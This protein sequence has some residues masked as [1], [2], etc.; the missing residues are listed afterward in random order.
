M[1]LS[2]VLLCSRFTLMSGGSTFESS[3][4]LRTPFTHLRARQ[5]QRFVEKRSLSFGLACKVSCSPQ[6]LRLD[7]CASYSS[8]DTCI[9]KARG[10]NRRQAAARACSTERGMNNKP[11]MKYVVVTGGTSSFRLLR[12]AC[13][14][15]VIRAS[16][17]C[18]L[19]KSST[20]PQI[21]PSDPVTSLSFLP[22]CRRR[23]RSWEGRDC[24]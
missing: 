3:T 22:R 16:L 17:S 24:Q 2:E 5:G 4:S 13:S 11:P 20:T 21:A 23:Q 10:K 8:A 9:E 18:R 15:F 7:A 1:K 6:P 14:I 19:Y 12:I